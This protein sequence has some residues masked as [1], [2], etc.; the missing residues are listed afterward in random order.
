MNTARVITTLCLPRAASYAASPIDKLPLLIVDGN[1]CYRSLG[2]L[3][4]QLLSLWLRDLSDIQASLRKLACYTHVREHT[5]STSA[6][7]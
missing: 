7:L 3:H 1:F 4:T 2:Q 6:G 5:C